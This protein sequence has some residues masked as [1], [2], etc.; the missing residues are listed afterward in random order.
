MLAHTKKENEK[1]LANK[2]AKKKK[3]GCEGLRQP[4]CEDC[5]HRCHG[6]LV[7]GDPHIGCDLMSPIWLSTAVAERCV[8]STPR[9][10]EFL[11][12]FPN[13]ARLALEP[14]PSPE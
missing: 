11:D 10:G 5:L 4:V 7:D 2:K 9:F 13:L 12:R 1:E 14:P 8:V 6:Y 3:N